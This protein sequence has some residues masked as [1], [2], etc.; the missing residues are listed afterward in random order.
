[1]GRKEKLQGILDTY[2]VKGNVINVIGNGRFERFEV[3]LEPSQ[4]FNK[5]KKLEHDIALAFGKPGAVRIITVP[6]KAYV[7]GIEIP[8]DETKE[9]DV[10]MTSPTRFKVG[11]TVDGK[12]VYADMTAMPHLLVSGTTG[13]GKSIFVNSL[14]TSILKQAEASDVQFVMVDM[15]QTELTP[16]DGIPHLLCPV[17]TEAETAIK[18]LSWAANEMDERY[19]KIRE[20]KMRDIK[21]YNEHHTEKMSKIIFIIDE[22]ADLMMVANKGRTKIDSDGNTLETLVARIAQKGRAAGIHLII[23]TQRPSKDV[24]TALIKDN[25]PSKV[26]FAVGD[27]IASKIAIGE[28]G[29]EN[30]LGKGDMLFKPIGASGAI[31]MQGEY[32]SDGDITELVERLSVG[33]LRHNEDLMSMLFPQKP[34][35]MT[36]DDL[37]EILISKYGLDDALNW[38]D[39]ILTELCGNGIYYKIHIKYKKDWLYNY[40]LRW[41][42][43]ELWGRFNTVKPFELHRILTLQERIET[44]E[45]MRQEYEEALE[46]YEKRLEEYRAKKWWQKLLGV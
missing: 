25:T 15:K 21:V 12:E 34:Y 16:Y 37:R 38:S 28:L 19:G 7:V 35:V 43:G 33:S 27:S 36:T 9:V 5:V 45:K 40:D 2:K 10:D 1:M 11:T 41:K 44:D 8:S 3:K 17:L 26:A 22:F 46:C 20:A 18:A 31:R 29:A 4:Q 23:A 14:I 6:N 32:I 39:D 30:L 13:S 42:N 24:V